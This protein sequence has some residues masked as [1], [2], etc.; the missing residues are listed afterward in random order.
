M[1]LILQREP[2]KPEAVFGTLSLDAQQLC[3]T[4]EDPVE[5]IVAGTYPIMLHYSFKF[6]MLL[7][8]IMGV[9]GRSDILMHPGNTELDTRGCILPGNYKVG[10]DT[11]AESRDALGRI[12]QRWRAWNDGTI[13]VVDS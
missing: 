7:P 3:L 4:L 9:A 1:T 11:V 10:D 5:L 8:E 2:P 12:L 6:R 13:V